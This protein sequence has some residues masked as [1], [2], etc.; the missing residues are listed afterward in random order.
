MPNLTKSLNKL[1]EQIREHHERAADGFRMT[2]WEVYEAGTLLIEARAKADG[3]WREWLAEKI[4]SL[5]LRTAQVYMQVARG[6]PDIEHAGPEAVQS[7][8]GAVKLLSAPKKE[9]PPR[10]E[11]EDPSERA[12][13][14]ALP[15]ETDAPLDPDRGPDVDSEPLDDDDPE[16][17]EDDDEAVGHVFTDPGTWFDDVIKTR[18]MEVAV[19]TEGAKDM[20]FP[21][22]QLVASLEAMAKQEVPDG[23]N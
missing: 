12:A 8:R 20:V 16:L 13:R 10:D 2:L 14:C 7:I 11:P 21:A 1:A 18:V 3:P 19:N 17:D 15:E 6:W 23:K 4:P 22:Q 5:P 9:D